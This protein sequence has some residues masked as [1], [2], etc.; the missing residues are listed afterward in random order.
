VSLAIKD[1]KHALS[2][3]SDFSV[4]LPGL[5]IAHNN[6]SASRDYAGE[7]LDSSSMYG[8]LRVNAVL[9]FWN[10]TSRQG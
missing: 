2:L 5:E 3:A 4:S 8:T 1:A 9:P 7:C 10:G 6:M